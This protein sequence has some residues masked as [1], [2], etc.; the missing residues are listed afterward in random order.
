MNKVRY[1]ITKNK[2]RKKIMKNNNNRNK[3]LLTMNN[4]NINQKKPIFLL[5]RIKKH[6]KYKINLQ[7]KHLLMYLNRKLK[8][9]NQMK[10]IHLNFK[11][12]NVIT[13]K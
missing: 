11:S 9:K 6:N 8:K 13:S 10:R 4:K 1:E 5:Y 12:Y 3:I 7:I 2:L